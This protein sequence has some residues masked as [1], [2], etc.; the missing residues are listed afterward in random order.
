MERTRL[1][2]LPSPS[3]EASRRIATAPGPS[4]LTAPSPPSSPSRIGR[5]RRT[6]FDYV[7]LIKPEITFLVTISAFAGYLL[8]VEEEWHLPRLVAL[9]V[10]VA[11]SS[12]GGATLNHFIERDKDARMKRTDQ[13]PLPA[14][15]IRPL[16]ALL[17]GSV[18]S[19]TGVLTLLA[20]TNP[21]TALL[22][23]LTIFLYVLLYTPLKTRTKYNTLVGT[24]PGALP[25]LGGWTA[26][27][28]TLGTGGWIV[29]AILV[30]WQLPHFFALAWMYRKDYAR[31]G[32]RML[33]VMEPDGRSTAQQVLAS[34][35][36]LLGACALPYFAGLAGV[37]YLAGAVAVSA[38]LVG[39]SMRFYRTL[40]NASARRVLKASIVHIPAI[41]LLLMIDRLL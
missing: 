16:A 19:L 14:G 18:L 29:F 5:V 22:A 33:P 13:R 28:G 15:R 32:F 9:L 40:S 8:G 37:M 26:A 34:S 1:S 4:T 36:L 27:T 41:V 11:C 23:G 25:A 3:H 20:F 31:A 10:G 39:A 30:I 12:G 17:F 35:L 2:S 21:L 24:I 7:S 38:W 6:I